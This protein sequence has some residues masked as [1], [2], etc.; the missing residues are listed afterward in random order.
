VQPMGLG[1]NKREYRQSQMPMGVDDQQNH[2]VP[3]V[4]KSDV[5]TDEHAKIDTEMIDLN[6]K[7]YRLHGQASNNQVWLIFIIN[8]LF[9]IIVE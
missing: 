2:I 1:E 6:M 5:F 3:F 9:H 8:H 7:P 4:P